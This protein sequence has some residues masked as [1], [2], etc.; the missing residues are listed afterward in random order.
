MRTR[1]L[2]TEHTEIIQEVFLQRVSLMGRG[3]RVKEEPPKEGAAA[4]GA[5]ASA[6]GRCKGPG[7]MKRVVEERP[8]SGLFNR[9]M[10]HTSGRFKRF[11]E[12]DENRFTARDAKQLDFGS[13]GTSITN[14]R[15]MQ[16]FRERP[17]ATGG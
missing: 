16:H 5:P 15:Q 13:E 3:S 7:V 14:V 2:S 11:V 10:G 17:P 4:K 1:E 9:R 8:T 12:K 6:N